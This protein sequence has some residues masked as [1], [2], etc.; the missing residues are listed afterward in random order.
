MVKHSAEAMFD[1]VN[2]VE[3]YPQFMPGCVEARVIS[4][5]GDGG[6]GGGESQ[7]VLAELCLSKA[8]ISRRI[9]TR[10][11]L[12]R[13]RSITMQ[14]ERGDLA[15]LDARWEFLPLPG[16]DTG[17]D[18]G[19]SS[20]K[21]GGNDSGSGSGSSTGS[22]S[23]G[24]D[25]CKVSLVMTFETPPGPSGLLLRTLI[26]SSVDGLVDALLRRANHLSLPP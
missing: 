20:S 16:G 19:N 9:T 17:R 10:N 24:S 26:N 18:S 6:D 2:D 7:V 15:S 23:K 5:D 14:L 1:L 22:S 8:G 3:A 13:P 4:R 12:L 21:D 11:R 25:G